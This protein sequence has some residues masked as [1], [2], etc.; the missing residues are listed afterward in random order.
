MSALVGWDA[1]ASCTFMLVSLDPVGAK[2]SG[3][4]GKKSHMPSIFSLSHSV[5]IIIHCLQGK[6]GILIYVLGIRILFVLKPPAQ[7][8]LMSTHC[9]G[10]PLPQICVFFL[11]PSAPPFLSSLLK[12]KAELSKGQFKMTYGVI[13]V[14][15]CI[16]HLATPRKCNFPSKLSPK[17]SSAPMAGGMRP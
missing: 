9:E 8:H 15:F 16:L 4:K 6:D 7:C 5:S 11:R 2:K 17:P 10:L 14:K 3:L 1:M 13:R 12:A